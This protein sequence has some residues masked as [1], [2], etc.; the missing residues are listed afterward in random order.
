MR[1]QAPGSGLAVAALVLAFLAVLIAVS[2]VMPPPARSWLTQT[3]GDSE[4]VNFV[5]GSRADIDKRLAAAAQSIDAL[6]SKEIDVAARLEAIETV[7]GSGAAMRRLDAVEA[8]LKAANQRLAAATGDADRMAAS[9]AE[10]LD[11]RLATFD[12]DLKTVQDKLAAAER[13]VERH[14]DRSPR[15]G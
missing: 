2:A 15:R 14:P 6:A 3:L 11:A 10:A 7:V 8:N 4:I 12:G 9:R 5:T 13:D 1:R